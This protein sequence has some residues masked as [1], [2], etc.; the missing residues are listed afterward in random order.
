MLNVFYVSLVYL[1][2]IATIYFTKNKIDNYDTKFYKNI[3]IVNIIG[4]L[5]DITQGLLIINHCSDFL[6]MM[7]NKLFLVYINVWTFLFAIYVLSIKSDENNKTNDVLKKIVIVGFLVFILSALALPIYYY[8]DGTKMYSYGIAATITYGAGLFYSTIMLVSMVINYPKVSKNIRRKYVPLLIFLGL[9]FVEAVIQIMY[10]EAL[11]LSPLETLV[12][13]LTYFFIENPDVQML[14]MMEA[15]KDAAEKA[16]HAKSDFLSSM[17]HEIRTPLNAIVGFSEDIQSRKKDADPVIIED[18]DYIM[19][20]SQ[21]L[22]EIIGNILDI[23]KI[24]SNKME[25]IDTVYNFKHEMETL[26]KIDSIRIGTKPI[27]FKVNIAEDIPYELYGDKA[28]MKEVVNNLLSNAFKYTNE[29]EVEFT[30]KC[31]NNRDICNLFI[32]VRDTGL[33]IKPENIQRLFSKFDRLDVERNTTVE[34][35]GL[36]LAITKKLVELMGGKINVQSQYGTG[37]IFMVQIPQKIAT[38]TQP[39]ASVNTSGADVSKITSVRSTIFEGKKLLVVDDNKL[40]I[41]VA[42]RALEGF[43]FEIDEC[44]DGKECLDKINSGNKYDLILLDIMMPNMGGEE[45]MK[46]LKEIPGFNIPVIALTADAL[47]GAC[48]KYISIGFS[49]YIAKPF[50]RDQIKEK[51]DKIFKSNVGTIPN[52]TIDNNLQ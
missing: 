52:F 7:F 19:E 35:T 12:T 14:R 8:Y 11:L 38:M 1:L 9:G 45:T 16:N 30:V 26:A 47:T 10:P 50:S 23:N 43:H 37:S 3:I 18:A 24:E 49:D 27:E 36:G 6:I 42:R 4:L 39:V 40:N 5:I 29:G 17:S 13:I 22:L 32:S 51:L 20:A 46:A 34:G 33:G 41:K 48:E 15:A 2:L 31:I 44:Y 25:I 21:T 28:H